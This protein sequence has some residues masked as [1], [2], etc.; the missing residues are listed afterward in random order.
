[1]LV[2]CEI[3]KA[4]YTRVKVIWI[5]FIGYQISFFAFTLNVRL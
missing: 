4:Y 2:T 3:E 1:M 5:L